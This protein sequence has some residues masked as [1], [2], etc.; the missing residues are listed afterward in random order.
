MLITSFILLL[1]LLL[2]I[3]INTHFTPYKRL[4]KSLC[5][6]DKWLAQSHQNRI[7]KMFS[8]ESESDFNFAINSVSDIDS[9]SK[10]GSESESHFN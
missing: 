6:Y 3:V 9:T 2:I 7:C 1:V 10:S 5:L 4:I 8:S